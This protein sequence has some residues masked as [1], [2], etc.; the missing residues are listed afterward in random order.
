MDACLSFRVD[1]D[2]TRG[3]ALE[4]NPAV[5]LVSLRPLKFWNNNANLLT[6]HVDLPIGRP[7]KIRLFIAGTAM[8]VLLDEKISLSRRIYS[9]P[10]GGLAL[11]FVDG[12]G[13]ISNVIIRKFQR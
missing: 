11:D 12:P 10:E 6:R 2:L 13:Q 5:S 1:P 9:H 3:Y 8:E 7:F 4:L